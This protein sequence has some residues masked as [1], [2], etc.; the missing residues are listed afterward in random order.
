MKVIKPFDPWQSNL[1][2]CPKKLTLN[3][4]TG[5]PHR[6]V[7]CYVSYIPNFFNCRPKKNLIPLLKGDVKELKG[8]IISISNSSDP[9]PY[10]EKEFKL[11][12][13]CLEI[14]LNANCRIQ[15]IT[16]STLITRDVDI[17]RKMKAMVALTITTASD[18][19]SKKLEPK[20]PLS[21][22][23]IEA[24]KTL[25][26]NE[27]P[28]SVRIDPV[29]PF[30]NEHQEE[31]IDTLAS[32]GVRHITSSTY[33]VKQDNWQ[34]FSL[35]FPEIAEKLKKLYFKEGERVGRSYYLPRELRFN[36]MKRIK[37]L[38][39]SRG[40]KFACCREGFPQLNSAVC[41]GSWLIS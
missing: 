9:Y 8:E 19:L 2:S 5:C 10:L 41:D 6:C 40:M 39:E 35:A 7:Y 25:I 14:L 23:R 24:V 20:A 15:I 17:L 29:I 28:F 31:L 12:R 32:L 16:K 1:C 33:K 18:K 11:T 34:R 13:K 21:S 36:L 30:L 3:P 38:V 22:E 37:S 4:Y 26:K 27:I